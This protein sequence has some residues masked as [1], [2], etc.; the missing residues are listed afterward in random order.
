MT[1][2]IFTFLLTLLIMSLLIFGVAALGELFPKIFTARLRYAA[3]LI[4]LIGLII[5]IRPMIGSGLIYIGLPAE[6]QIQQNVP[7]ETATYEP[8]NILYSPQG[9]FAPELTGGR[10]ER[11]LPDFT[12]INIIALIW[13]TGAVGV[14]AFH[15]WRYAR[16]IRLI[17]RWSMAIED[18]TTLSIFKNVQSE[19][20]L[21]NKH[22]RLRRCSFVSTSLLIG[23]LRPMVLLPQKHFE[24][25]ELEMIFRHELIHYKRRDLLAKL[26]MMI[27]ASVYWFNPAIYLMNAAMQADCEASC[28]EAVLMEVGRQNNQYYAELIIEMISDKKKVGTVLSTCFYGSK[29]SVKKRMGAI[30]DTT[31]HTRTLSFA[32]L[33]AVI[34]LTVLSGSVFAFSEQQGVRQTMLPPVLAPAEEAAEQPIE[35]S[36]EE[37]TEEPNEEPAEEPAEEAAEEPAGEAIEEPAEEASEEEQTADEYE[38]II[39]IQTPAGE[40][41]EAPVYIQQNIPAPNHNHGHN[42]GHG[43]G[44]QDHEHRNRGNNRH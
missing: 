32:A 38:Q 33:C 23:F 31:G 16:F 20:G 18:E 26:A 41:E 35:E 8:Q 3:W 25:D 22:I 4:I 19:K 44:R 14:S 15:I 36:A 7:G 43:Q 17:K 12:P 39:E 29:R 24:S 11:V 6:T 1:Q 34:A 28:D 9:A 21:A 2:N 40:Q 5:P 42:Q 13:L 37:A 30:M 27:A 10:A